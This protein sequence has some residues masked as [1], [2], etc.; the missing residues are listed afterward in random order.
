[1]SEQLE[2]CQWDP[3]V[4][5]E[6]FL[7]RSVTRV[8]N[9]LESAEARASFLAD[10]NQRLDDPRLKMRALALCKSLF[11]ADGS[12]S[13]DE[14]TVFLEMEKAFAVSGSGSK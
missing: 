6:L 10:V 2:Q 11:R 7:S 9:A 13:A 14:Q 12:Y 4:P 1:V 5:M 8:R 3:A